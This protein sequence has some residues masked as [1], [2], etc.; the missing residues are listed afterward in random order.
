MG[1]VA[2]REK[3]QEYIRVADYKKVTIY[4][5]IES[6]LEKDLWHNNELLLDAW[7]NDYKNYKIGKEAGFKLNEVEKHFSKKTKK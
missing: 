2:I 4:T 3:L 5:M 6:D 1:A 7:D